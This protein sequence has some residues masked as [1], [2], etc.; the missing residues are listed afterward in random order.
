MTIRVARL[1]FGSNGAIAYPVDGLTIAGNLREMFAAI[2]AVGADV[3]RRS[4]VSMGSLLIGRM[5]VAGND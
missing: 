2:E 4:N 1:A 5:T 3:D